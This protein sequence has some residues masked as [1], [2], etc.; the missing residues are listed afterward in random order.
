MC[1]VSEDVQQEILDALISIRSRLPD[2]EGEF[3]IDRHL[4][5]IRDELKEFNQLF[6]VRRNGRDGIVAGLNRAEDRIGTILRIFQAAAIA[7]ALA[8]GG[9]LVTMMIDY[10]SKVKH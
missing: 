4:R 9:L 3:P 1:P 10:A 6:W 8:A 2:P 5:E 7:F